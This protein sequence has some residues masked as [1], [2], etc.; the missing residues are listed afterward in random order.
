MGN[1]AY[2]IPA[3][4]LINVS[5]CPPVPEVISGVIAYYLAW[6]AAPELDELNRPTA[7][8]GRTVHHTCSR[9]P[10][11]RAGNYAHSF[12]DDGAKQGYCLVLLGCRGP[13][14]F[15]ACSSVKWNQATSFPMHSG[16]GCLGCS[17]PDF[18]DQTPGFYG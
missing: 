9:L 15:N 5:G 3:K 14:T 4:P 18:W 10:H 6:G 11:F 16:H 13:S 2:D 1:P 7:F 17:Q 12:D 8:Y